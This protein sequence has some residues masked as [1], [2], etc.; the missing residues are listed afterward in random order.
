MSNLN[1]FALRK[2]SNSWVIP[3]SLLTLIV[4]FLTSLA[5][6]TQADRTERLSRLS[7]DIRTRL[8]AGELDL[9]AEYQSVR[10]EVAKLRADKGRLENLLAQGQNASKEINL[11]LQEAKMFAGLTEV[12]GP[13]ILVT[14]NDSQRPA[15]DAFDPA[16]QIIHDT[17]VVKVVN[18]LWAAGAEAISVNNKR[19]GPATSFRC[20]GPTILVDGVKIASPV[21]IRA[22]GD[23]ETLYGGMLLPGGILDEIKQYDPKM[24]H[25]EPVKKMRMPAFAGSTSP[26]FMKTP[27]DERDKSEDKP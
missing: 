3:V 26:K 4:G 15:E 16:G 10:E 17:D 22:I 14:L 7:P 9:S 25:V 12:E 24:V 8:T 23:S 11:S 21:Q 19:V 6:I 20:V 5:W 1:P 18:E 2:S 27:A 13:G